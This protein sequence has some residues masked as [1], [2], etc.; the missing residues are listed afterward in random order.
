MRFLYYSD[1]LCIEIIRFSPKDRP[2]IRQF[3]EFLKILN[4]KL[5]I[6]LSMFIIIIII[7]DLTIN[8]R[9]TAMKKGIFRSVQIQE[10]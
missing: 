9:S 3:F 5:I 6:F 10:H 7:L 8:I 2:K 1:A 4:K